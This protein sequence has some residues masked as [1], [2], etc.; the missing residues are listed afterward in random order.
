MSRALSRCKMV[1]ERG[2]G[3]EL[4]NLLCAYPAV[5]HTSP[6]HTQHRPQYIP[7]TPQTCLWFP[8]SS[9]A[10]PW[11]QQS[12]RGIPDCM[13]LHRACE[14]IGSPAPHFCWE[15]VRGALCE[16]TALCHHS[17]VFCVCYA[18]CA[19][20][21]ATSGLPSQLGLFSPGPSPFNWGTFLCT[22]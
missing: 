5:M 14:Y 2:H 9:T 7:A 11:G 22:Y 21:L 18:V 15:E 8:L 12:W 1:G 3:K 20:H 10:G 17:G 13:G 6:V 19:H 4:T 16:H